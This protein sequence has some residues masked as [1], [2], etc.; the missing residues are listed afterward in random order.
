MSAG[1][2]AVTWRNRQTSISAWVF[3]QSF[4]LDMLRRRP[5]APSAH[6]YPRK[7]G[8]SR[9]SEFKGLLRSGSPI[10]NL[11]DVLNPLID[12]IYS[13]PESR[14]GED[15]AIADLFFLSA[16]S[17]WADLKWPKFLG[18][19]IGIMR[20]WTPWYPGTD[21]DWRIQDGQLTWTVVH[22]FSIYQHSSWLIS[23]PFWSLPSD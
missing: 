10:K 4:I 13:R 23:N 14:I 8:Q 19:K 11:A 2:M 9:Y 17:T 15:L 21:T 16:S 6:T 18:F 22:R 1:S 3:A 12:W 5:L 7:Y 20:S